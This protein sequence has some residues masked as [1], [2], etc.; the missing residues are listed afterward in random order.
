MILAFGRNGLLPV[1]EHPSDWKEF[2]ARF[3]GTPDNGRR[4]KLMVGLAQI[5][6]LL[7]EAECHMVWIDG[8]FVTRERWP[9]D[10]DV[11]YDPQGMSMNLL[12]S[13]LQDV[14][15]GR[16]AQKRRFGGEALAAS[17]PIE[18]NGLTVR[19]AFMR[20]REGE[21][22]GIIRLEMTAIRPQLVQFL[23]GNRLDREGSSHETS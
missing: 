15:E 14:S 20:T 2:I 12:P 17:F 3:S 16:A 5:L 22:K 9:R 1:G 4:R 19:E 23:L 8:S 21:A 13:E 6:F 7:V 18:A 10:F 11:C